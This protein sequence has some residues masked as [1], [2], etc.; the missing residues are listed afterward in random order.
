M[1]F[2]DLTLTMI[3]GLITVKV[4]ELG[5]LARLSCSA[6]MLSRHKY[7]LLYRL[8]T[9]SANKALCHDYERASDCFDHDRYQHYPLRGGGSRRVSRNDCSAAEPATR[10]GRGFFVARVLRLARTVP[11]AVK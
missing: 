10:N 11:A 2:V 4:N 3:A 7:E 9:H 5:G 8:D 1:A 6:V